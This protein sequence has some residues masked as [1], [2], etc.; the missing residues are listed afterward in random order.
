[1]FAFITEAGDMD[2]RGENVEGMPVG[3]DDFREVRDLDLYFVDKTPLID[4]ILRDP[5]KVMLFTR[6]RRFGKS[7]NM[8]MLDAYLNI[9]YA[10][11]RDRFSDL[12]ISELR[13]DD[14]EKNG[15]IIISLNFKGLKTQS[16]DI[17]KTSFKNYI[18]NLYGDFEELADSEKLPPRF[19][20]WYKELAEGT[21]DYDTLTNSVKYL[22]QMIE[23]HHGKKPII[24]IDEYDHPMNM[25][26]GRPELHED[27]KGLMRDFLGEA[28]K[29]NS[30]MRFA[31]VTGVMKISKESIF[32]GVNNPNVFDVLSAGFDEMFGFTQAEVEKLLIDN[33]HGDKIAEA[34][35]WYDGYRFGD[36]DIYN[37]WSIIKYAYSGCKPRSYWAGT[38]GNSIMEDLISRADSDTWKELETL[39]SGGSVGADLSTEV[40]Y[41]DLHSP[42]DSIYSV[43]V[44]SGYLKAIPQGNGYVVSIP[45]K[46]MFSVFAATILRRY[47]KSVNKDVFDLIEAM[48]C[49]DT[50]KMAEILT[51]QFELL[52]NRILTHEHVYQGFITGLMAIFHGRYE[53]TAEREIKK[54]YYDVRLKRVSGPGPNVVLEIKRRNEKNAHMTMEELAREG[55]RQIHE[56]GYAD[57]LTGETMIYGVAFDGKDPT[58]AMEKL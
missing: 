44:A 1:M 20:R 32:S 29:T 26:Y 27:V 11:E 21:A 58:I 33:G 49:G 53:V 57:G 7:L 5:S 19:I 8:S 3:N 37:P 40:S 16:Y 30:N 52:S 10:G 22:C 4:M 18:I 42:T 34:R 6:P 45:N 25:T 2:A 47:G 48:A 12:K 17:F 14:T 54:G 38:S 50:V 24:L 31:V 36:A 23:M 55:L 56:K 15:N 13:P 43:M 41:C 35:E 39:C 28:L 51:R 9:K 46:E